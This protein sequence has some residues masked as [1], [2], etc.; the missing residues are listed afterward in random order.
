MAQVMIKSKFKSRIDKTAIFLSV[1]QVS[2]LGT[3]SIIIY[4]EDLKREEE[5]LIGGE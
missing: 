3:K 4:L 5:E 1:V 2:T